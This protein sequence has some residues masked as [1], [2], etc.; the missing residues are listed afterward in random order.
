MFQIFVDSAANIPAVLVAKYDIHVIS[1]MNYVDGKPLPGFEAGL[2]PE[3]ERA[4]GKLYYDAIRQGTEVKTS[5]VNTAQFLDEFRP[6]VEA[7]D[8]VL[9][10]SLSK[11]ISGTNHS[12]Q[13]AADE[14]E[15]EFPGRKVYV[16]D[17]LNASLAQGILAIYA[18]E[19]ELK[20]LVLSKIA[21]LLQDTAHYMNGVF[22][23]ED[24]KYLARSGRLSNST[25][26]I[27]NMLSIKP[28][29]K[30]NAEGFIVQFRKCRGRK[31]ALNDLVDIVCDNILEPAKQIIGI[32]HAD[33]YDEALEFMNKVRERGVQVREFIDTSYDYCT[34]SHVGP[35]TI[36]LFFIGPDREL[37]GRP[38][39]VV[40]PEIF[41]YL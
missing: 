17:S 39:N 2:T 12:A 20:G 31:K 27:G 21:Q 3:E 25:A 19:L 32:A 10:I 8:D 16:V 11:N 26:F 40:L 5:L 9:Y 22:T 30:G 36:A 24:L 41:D 38:E 37:Q 14:L 4:K 13:M 18:R 35:G 28:L 6:C 29:L 33:A 15:E 1:F 23:V 7:G 34:G